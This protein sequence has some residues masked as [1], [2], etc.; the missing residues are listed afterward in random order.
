M[1]AYSIIGWIVALAAMLAAAAPRSLA[2]QA[3]DPYRAV[4]LKMV[5]EFIEQEG[6]RNPRVLE[7]MRTVPRHEFVPRS[8]A[9]RAYTDGAW[10][11]GHGQTISPPFIVAYM[12]E[13]IDP[14]ETDR[15]LEIGTGSGYQAAVLSGLV[16]DV[17]TIEIVEPLGRQAE[18]RLELLGY[19]NV[20]VKVGDGY[21]GWPEHAPF[22]KI[23]VTCSPEKIPQ[24]LVEQ[25]KEGGRMIIP[26]GERYQQVFHLLEKKDGQLVRRRLIPTLF[27]PMTGISEERREV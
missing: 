10:P 2:A 23:I 1:Q 12:T 11:I 5:E 15:V 16:Q 17:Y 27:V 20:H 24:P 7:A 22:D 14:Q 25:L 18:R 6:V 3:R 4:R 8:L 9:S 26:L 19:D 13:T 21:Q